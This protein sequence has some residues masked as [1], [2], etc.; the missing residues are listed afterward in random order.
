MSLGEGGAA[1]PEKPVSEAERLYRSGLAA[2]RSGDERIAAE[3]FRQAAEKGHPAATT[4]L[5]LAYEEGR[6]V[7]R[8]A[9]EAA[10][11]LNLAADS[12]EPRAQYLVGSAFYLGA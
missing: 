5:G 8:D 2:Q 4:E 6:G 10:R 12:G 11:L 9:A 3:R 1:A 7:D